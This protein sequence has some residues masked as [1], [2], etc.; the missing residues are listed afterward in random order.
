MTRPFKHT[1]DPAEQH[2][3]QQGN[4]QS[5]TDSGGCV[6]MAEVEKSIPRATQKPH[7]K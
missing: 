5:S 1:D 6:D 7:G 4:R 2:V 3:E